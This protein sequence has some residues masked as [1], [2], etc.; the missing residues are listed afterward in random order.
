LRCS[1]SAQFDRFFKAQSRQFY[2][3]LGVSL[4]LVVFGLVMV[5]SSSSIDSLKNNGDSFAVFGRQVIFAFFGLAGMVITSLI[6]MHFF[7]QRSGVIFALALGT[8][9]AVFLPGLGVTVNGNTNW[10]RLG[11]FAVQPSEFIKLSLIIFISAFMATRYNE[12]FDARRFMWPILCIGLAPVVLVMLGQ[13]LGT[14]IIIVLILFGSLFLA[15]TPAV[16]MR[17]P[18][19]IVIIGGA[20]AASGGSRAKRI[21]AWLNPTD[22]SSP[23][24]WQSLHG[25]WALAAGRITGAGLGQSRMKWSWIPEVENDYIFAIIGEEL[26]LIGALIVIALFVFLTGSM[27]QIFLRTEDN[28][29]RFV[30]GGI[31]VWI[32]LQSI[33]NIMVV[34]QLA[35]VLG[36]PLPL[37]SAGGSS[38]ISSLLAIGV[39]LAI[40]RQNHASGA[41]RVRNRPSASRPA[42]KPRTRVTK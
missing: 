3:L 20:L 10:L 24:T 32:S 9:L 2:N 8:Q 26:G 4:L 36:V 1:F 41:S 5:L 34:L 14:T 30:A 35:P 23:Y 17:L 39:M 13:D 33:I 6:P 12:M 19:L 22:D 11:I 18:A 25:I 28:F 40:E 21:L 31:M 27:I 15:G 7:R 37:I 29:A 38:L 42:A 16:S